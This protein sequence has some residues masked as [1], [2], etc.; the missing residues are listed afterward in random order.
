MR[1]DTYTAGSEHHVQEVDSIRLMDLAPATS[2]LLS[3][4]RAG[5]RRDP[6]TLPC[7]Y[8]Y[9]QRGSELFERITELR[10]YYPTRTELQIMADHAGEMA[11]AIGPDAWLVEFGSG[12][13]LKTERLLSALH[14]PAGCV[15]VDISKSALISSARHLSQHFPGLDVLAVCADYTSDFSLPRPQPAP[16]RITGYFPGSTI[17]NFT[18]DE[19]RTFLTRVRRLVGE[20]G[21]LLVGFDRVKAVP[22]LEAAYND[23]EGVTAAFNLNLLARLSQAGAQ[24]QVEGFEHRAV[25]NP[26]EDRI[27][28]LLVSRR[29][30]TLEVGGERFA[31]E[32]GE[33]IC[34]EHSHKY[35]LEDFLQLAHE[36]GFEAD[37][38]W[39]DPRDWFSVCH[40]VAR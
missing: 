18:R 21:S 23:G 28:M 34:T 7:K 10:E 36:A 29:D 33:A 16:R 6:K 13:G 30:Q 24:V 11:D 15:L 26:N 20:G 2:D 4:A 38:H 19:A 37:R 9:D 40:V 32:Q 31:V 5:L 8:F 39:S 27:E 25:Y 3:D 12:S 1:I 14:E 35:R 22:V 17:G